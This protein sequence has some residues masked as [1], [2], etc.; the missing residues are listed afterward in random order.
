MLASCFHPSCK[1]ELGTVSFHPFL[2][3]AALALKLETSTP[4][5]TKPLTFSSRLRLKAGSSNMDAVGNATVLS[6][7]ALVRVR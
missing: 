3:T 7:E 1:V 2:V 4:R 6:V 5:S